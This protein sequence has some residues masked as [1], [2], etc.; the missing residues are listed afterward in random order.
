MYRR[1]RESL[2]WHTNRQC[3]AWPT[4]NVQECKAPAVGQVCVHCKE[5]DAERRMA[6]AEADRKR[7]PQSVTTAKKASSVS[8]PEKRHP[9]GDPQ[10]Q[11]QWR[12]IVRNK[13]WYWERDEASTVIRTGP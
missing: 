9:K 6:N 13:I 7:N 2:V 11:V 1:S 3:S 8:T 10:S 12:F 5:L 4:M